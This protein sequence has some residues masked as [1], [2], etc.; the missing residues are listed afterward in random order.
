MPV[1]LAHI[2]RE[3]NH[4]PVNLLKM[5]SVELVQSW[6]H[7]SFE[8]L[9]EFAKI[10][11]KSENEMADKFDLALKKIR[12]RH[13]TVVETM[14]Q[15]IIEL[16]ES[17]GKDALHPSIQYFLDR[18]YMNRIGIRTLIT[19]HLLICG[20]EA[21]KSK[22]N[23]IGCFDEECS[24]A[25][26]VFDAATNARFLCEQ[27]YLC[28]PDVIIEEHNAIED[29]ERIPIRMTYV[30]SHLYHMVFELLKNSMRAVVEKNG[31]DRLPEVKV[32]IT[33]GKEDHT[34]KISDRGGGI[35]KSELEQLFLYHYTTAP[36]PVSTGDV[37]ALAGYGYGLPLSRL[38][39]KYF[40]GDLQLFSM[41]GY[42]TDALIYI[43][44]VLGEATEVLP[45]YNKRTSQT[46]SEVKQS[47]NQMKDWSSSS[48]YDG[49]GHGY[50]RGNA[51]K[52]RRYSTMV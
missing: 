33:K 9:I 30:P 28:S 38:Y 36:Q 16:K 15:G 39:A 27:V 26:V 44:A 3:I 21:G 13:D 11:G 18:F 52:V 5:P 35:P 12:S 10:R 20:E 4:L 47:V 49:H 32:L 23:W 37:P 7:R 29:N 24:I 19:Q 6:Y 25:S 17:H 43:K 1:R 45:L 48:Y 40:G 2:I 46:Y 51:Y 22:T 41:E 34:I 50:L 14:A 31:E 42:G 8:D